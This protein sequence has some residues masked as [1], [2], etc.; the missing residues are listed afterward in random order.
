MLIA[1]HSTSQKIATLE[2]F[3]ETLLDAWLALPSRI[4]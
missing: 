1:D 2:T 3:L 4:V